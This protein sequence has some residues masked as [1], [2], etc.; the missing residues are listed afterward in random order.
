VITWTAY[1]HAATYTILTYLST[2]GT[3]PGTFSSYVTGKTGTSYTTTAYTS[4]DNIWYEIEAYVGTYWLS[5]V[6]AY[7]PTMRAINSSGVCS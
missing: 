7:T 2:S 3:T 1:S 4:K 6:S 5:V